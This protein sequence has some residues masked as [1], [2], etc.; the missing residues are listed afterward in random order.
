MK[1]EEQI[2]EE[3]KKTISKKFKVNVKMETIIS[4]T[5]IDSLDLLD[6]VV[7]VEKKYKIKIDDN[8]LLNIKT[9]KDIVDNIFSKM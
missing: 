9:V 5:G 3:V 4:E 8:S 2:F 6:L 1:K 7:E